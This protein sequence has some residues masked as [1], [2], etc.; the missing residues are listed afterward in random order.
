MIGSTYLL[1]ALATFAVI[2]GASFLLYRG[3][4]LR[5]KRNEWRTP[6]ARLLIVAFFGPYG[7]LWA[8]RRYRHKTKHAKFLLVPVFLICRRD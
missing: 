2:N 6:E 8:M 1:I 5:A 7:A 4:K 3:D